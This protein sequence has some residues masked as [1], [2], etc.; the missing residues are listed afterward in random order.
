[1]GSA[2]DGKDTAQL[3]SVYNEWRDLCLGRMRKGWEEMEFG[4]WATPYLRPRPPMEAAKIMTLVDW[5][6]KLSRLRQASSSR[7]TLF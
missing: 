7:R 5:R 1:M 3:A 6:S 2:V 4:G